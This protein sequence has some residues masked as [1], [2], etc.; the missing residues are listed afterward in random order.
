[1]NAVSY[2]FDCDHKDCERTDA[3]PVVFT[4]RNRDDELV[5]KYTYCFCPEHRKQLLSLKKTRTLPPE[6]WFRQPTEP[7]T[8]PMPP[9]RR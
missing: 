4:C 7:V 8:E 9:S 5:G 2:N 6:E 3:A 1:V